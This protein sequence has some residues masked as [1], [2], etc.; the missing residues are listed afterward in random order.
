MSKPQIRYL[1][2]MISVVY[3]KNFAK[4]HPDL[5][6][7]YMYRGVNLEGG[8]RYDITVI[9]AQMLGKE[10]TRTKGNR[11]SDNLPELY[12]V[13]Q[14]NAIFLMQKAKDSIVKQ[15]IA[16]KAKKGD[17]ILVSA[18]YAV[19]VINPSNKELKLGN[20]VSNRNKNIYKELEKMGGACYFY[21]INGW[22][23]NKKYKKVPEIEF[24]KALKSKPKNLNFLK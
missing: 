9:P 2:E 3:D 14:G 8:I 4:K 16:V 17:Y 24:L 19:V 18:E 23:K 13:L 10:F 20:W 15:V 12:T 21:T 1:K 11:N 5:E 22:V 7:Y 6:L